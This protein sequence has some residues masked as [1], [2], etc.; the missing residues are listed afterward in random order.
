MAPTPTPNELISDEI[1]HSA[2]MALLSREVEHLRPERGI[3]KKGPN[4]SRMVFANVAPV[5]LVQFFCIGFVFWD[6]EWKSFFR[7]MR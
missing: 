4:S 5:F 2:E 1:Y 3:L 7:T 6:C